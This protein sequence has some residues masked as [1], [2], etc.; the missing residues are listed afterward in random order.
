MKILKRIQIMNRIIGH[1]DQSKDQLAGK[2]WKIQ[3]VSSETEE[4]TDVMVGKKRYSGSSEHEETDEENNIEGKKAAR[5]DID[6]EVS[7]DSEDTDNERGKLEIM[8]LVEQL[9]KE[10]KCPAV[11]YEDIVIP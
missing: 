11:K 1:K 9:I 2:K 3:N 10:A 5:K 6:N 4:E 8:Q 7:S